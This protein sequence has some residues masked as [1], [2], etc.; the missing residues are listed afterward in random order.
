MDLISRK[1]K[2]RSNDKE[3]IG[4]VER[5]EKIM[6]K[7]ERILVEDSRGEMDKDL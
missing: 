1:R 4:R 5:K 2:R 3:R 6:D 7:E